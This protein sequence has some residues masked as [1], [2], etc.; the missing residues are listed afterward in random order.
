MNH[1]LVMCEDLEGAIMKIRCFKNFS[2]RQLSFGNQVD[3]H[4]G[5]T[6]IELLIFFLSSLFTNIPKLPYLPPLVMI[7]GQ[8]YAT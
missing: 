3:L 8:Y 2:F 4:L 6:E 7:V 5:E 1:G